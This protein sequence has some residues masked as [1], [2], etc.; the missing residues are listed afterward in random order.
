MATYAELFVLFLMEFFRF[1]ICVNIFH[2]V[3]DRLDYYKGFYV[4]KPPSSSLVFDEVADDFLK[5]DSC[6]DLKIFEE[7]LDIIQRLFEI[8]SRVRRDYVA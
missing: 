1:V 4:D 2:R 7:I 8:Y 6:V 5:F 3:W